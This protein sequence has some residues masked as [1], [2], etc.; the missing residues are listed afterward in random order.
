MSGRVLCNELPHTSCLKQTFVLVSLCLESG[1]NLLCAF[2]CRRERHGFGWD[3]GPTWRLS[4]IDEIKSSQPAPLRAST[5]GYCLEMSLSPLACQL[6]QRKAHHIASHRMNEI[7]GEIV[8]DG[9][10][11]SVT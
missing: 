4:C 2:V 5:P 6:L 10:Q 1:C 11:T 7:V 8:Q 9:S 3:C